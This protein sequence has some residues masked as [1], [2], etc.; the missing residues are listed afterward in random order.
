MRSFKLRKPR[1]RLKSPNPMKTTTITIVPKN[2]ASKWVALDAMNK[3]VAE[4]LTPD[5][6]RKQA[7]KKESVFF[8]MYIPDEGAINYY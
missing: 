7:E 8:L 6:V 2:P 1:K 5:D 3:I 4:G